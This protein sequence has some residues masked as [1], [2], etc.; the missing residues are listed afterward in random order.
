MEF[1]NRIILTLLIISLFNLSYSFAQ[2]LDPGLWKVKSE[3]KLNGIPLPTS[4]NEDCITAAEAHDAKTTVMK[5]LKRNDCTILNWKVKG[6]NLTATIKCKTSEIQAE[7]TLTGQ[8]SARNYHL[9]GSAKGT[10]QGIIPSEATLKL[11]GSWLRDCKINK[12]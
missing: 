11:D 12:F 3:F 2:S 8:F 10:Y 1:M 7:G 5:E 6:K 4:D 9:S